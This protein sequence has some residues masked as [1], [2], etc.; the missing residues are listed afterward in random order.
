MASCNICDDEIT[1]KNPIFI[2]VRCD[3]KVH[4]LCYGVDGSPANWKCSPCRLEMKQSIK[5]KLC[6]QKGGAMKQTECDNWVHVICGLFMKG[7]SF[8][9]EETMEPI[10][11]SKVPNSLRGKVCS[12]CNS[13]KGY[14][15]T[16]AEAKCK[17]KFHITCAQTEN[18][19]KEDVNPKSNTIKFQ[20]FCIEHKPIGSSRRLSSGSIRDGVDMKRQMKSNDSN[21]D[22]DW[23][24]NAE[25]STPAKSAK[26][27]HCE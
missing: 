20:A 26:K 25:T 5:C 17:N 11:I 16:C 3:L 27:R 9:N 14:C 24:L 21:G 10:N 22:A 4:K 2:C 12:I 8:S 1:K 7:V 13:K 6:C 15:T 23:I 18:T 19:L